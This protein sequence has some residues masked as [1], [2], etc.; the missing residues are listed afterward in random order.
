MQDESKTKKQLINEV[1]K[2][3]RQIAKLEASETRQKYEEELLYI[4]R[5]SSPI[6]LFIIQDGKFQF[7]NNIFRGVT[8]GSPDDLL[9][10]D[11][12][13]LIYPADR[14]MVRECAIQMLKGERSSPYPYRIISRDGQINWMM[15][16]IS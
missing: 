7:V 9:D 2:L 4:F 3:R 1:A 13:R 5:I 15:D 6:G 11:P 8:G 16:D 12:R 10:T 14:Q